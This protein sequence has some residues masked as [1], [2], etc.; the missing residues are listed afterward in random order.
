MTL[1]IKIKNCPLTI[2]ALSISD[3]E[4]SKNLFHWLVI[5]AAGNN[6]G[7]SITVPLTSCLTGLES[8]V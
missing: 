3:E 7:E 1:S 5:V 4:S 2:T 6:K 8:A